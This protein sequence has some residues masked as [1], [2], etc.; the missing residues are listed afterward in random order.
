MKKIP[1]GALP[2]HERKTKVPEESGAMW[3]DKETDQDCLGFAANVEV[4][5]RCCTNDA[6]SPLT[7]GIFGL[8]GSGKTSLM[9]MLKKRIEETNAPE[10]VLTLW[11]NAWRYEGRDEAQ[12]AL[13]HAIV[14]RISDKRTLGNEAKDLLKQ[15]L[16]GASVMKLAKVI[17]KSLITMTPD[18]DGFLNCFSD[19]SK[20]L[21]ETMEGFERD[22][23][24]L[25]IQVEVD[26]VVVF[27]DDLDRCS[28]DKV[29]ETFETIKLF[30]NTPRCTFVIGADPKRIEEAV[31]EV[32][33]ANHKTRR[34]YLEKIVQLPFQIPEQG[35]RD[36]QC[37]VGLLVLQPYLGAVLWQ[38]LLEYRP[39]LYASSTTVLDAQKAWLTDRRDK[40][41]DVFEKAVQGL[42][43]V[44]SQATTIARGL[45]GNP[46][47]V[48]RFLNIL[49]LRE[50]LAAANGLE[51]DHAYLTKLAV[52]EYTWREFFETLVESV[53]PATGGS[54]FLKELLE[55]DIKELGA[56]Q[57]SALL[58]GAA[59]QPG[60]ITF[61][62]S[63]PTLPTNLN[64]APYLF[65][66]QTSF[67][68]SSQTGLATLDQM[69]TGLV[70]RIATPDRVRSRAAARRAAQEEAAVL[71]DIIRA[72]ATELFAKDDVGTRTN[73]IIGLDEICRKTPRHYTVAVEA[74]RQLSGDI[75]EPV[76]LAASTLLGNAENHTDVGED[77]KGRF[78]TGEIVRA[79]MSRRSSQRPGGGR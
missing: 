44:L 19:E 36:I 25:L 47:Q 18:L 46:R 78:A 57:D 35:L 11:F 66:A 43:R 73:I 16:D 58:A 54:E 17:T 53:D 8:W 49:A 5:A 45:H 12:S 38:E 67:G 22:F 52:L 13:I 2:D 30:L 63:E 60:L 34:D 70:E 39:E 20:K 74:L 59:K 76:G 6:L 55:K 14:R 37:Y 62:K 71:D 77:L 9:M 1:S 72:L 61:L 51:I 48:K 29:V 31:G 3:S 40:L 56:S 50:Q 64:L 21:A 28:S 24:K 26:T 15:I 23:K 10:R 79:L 75:P 68:S 27:I 41:G 33:G 65:L 32:Y 42:E 7:L 4:L 69:V